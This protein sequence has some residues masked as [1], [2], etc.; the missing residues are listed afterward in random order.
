MA[1]VTIGS[2]QQTGAYTYYVMARGKMVANGEG[3]LAAGTA[4]LPITIRQMF[5]PQ[6]T[7]IVSALVGGELLADSITFS[8]NGVFENSVSISCWIAGVG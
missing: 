4:T 7:I 3:T 1:T 6:A 5:T 8:V 2:S